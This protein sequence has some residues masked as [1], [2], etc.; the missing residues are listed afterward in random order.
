VGKENIQMINYI[1]EENGMIFS[2][3]GWQE[4][5]GKPELYNYEM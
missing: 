3:S 4:P 1:D 5:Y 2:S